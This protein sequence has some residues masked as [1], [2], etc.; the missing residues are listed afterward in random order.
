MKLFSSFLLIGTAQVLEDKRANRWVECRFPVG[1][2]E[3][4][5]CRNEPESGAK[6]IDLN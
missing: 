4:E 5:I 6:R 3:D 1:E 2:M